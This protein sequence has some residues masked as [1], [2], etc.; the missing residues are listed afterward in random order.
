M[1]YLT[2]EIAKG[3]I[4]Y[5][6]EVNNEKEELIDTIIQLINE[7]ANIEDYLETMKNKRGM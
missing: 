1:V 3:N 6:L 5:S 2:K 4:D 7:S